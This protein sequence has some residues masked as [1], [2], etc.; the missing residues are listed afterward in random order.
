MS[1]AAIDRSGTLE[2]G[3]LAVGSIGHH[4]GG[5]WGM[6]TLIATEGFLFVYLEF[7]YY[8]FASHYGREWLPSELPSF[9]LSGPGT[10]ILILS[11]VA[12]WW[13]ERGGKSGSRLKLLAGLFIA[14]VLGVVFVALQLR[15]WSDKPFTLASHSYASTYF[16]VTGFHMA[17]VIAGLLALAVLI[18]W[19]GL[20]YFDRARFAPVSIG[21]VYWHFVDVVWLTVFVAFYVTPYLR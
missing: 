7:S 11:S 17:H 10:V 21:I 20:G 16:V 13:G 5:W 12:A 18:L 15:E 3:R 1:D 4:A 2:V 9:R 14:L 8:Y 19:S 6:M